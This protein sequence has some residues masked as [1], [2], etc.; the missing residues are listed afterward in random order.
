MNEIIE[1]FMN[2]MGITYNIELTRS[3]IFGGKRYVCYVVYAFYQGNTEYE[4]Y[5]CYSKRD[6]DGAIIYESGNQV[7]GP[8]RGIFA[9]ITMDND[10]HRYFENKTRNKAKEY[11]SDI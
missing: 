2:G 11:L 9:Y 5:H 4:Q 3:Q 7:K 1:K 10:V 8:G 6:R